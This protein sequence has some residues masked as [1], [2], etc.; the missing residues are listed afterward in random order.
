MLAKLDHF[1]QFSGW[2]KHIWNP[3]P[4][5]LDD[6]EN[7][8]LFQARILRFHVNLPRYD[9]FTSRPNRILFPH[10]V[11]SRQM[12]DHTSR[13]ARRTSPKV[14]LDL[15]GPAA[16]WGPKE[17]PWILWRFK[18]KVRCFNVPHKTWDMLDWKTNNW[19]KSSWTH[20][21]FFVNYLSLESF[22]CQTSWPNKTKLAINAPCP[23]Q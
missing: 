21:H 6:L 11:F 13:R 14:L 22:F 18:K 2:N 20:H 7:D 23:S 4:S 16:A 15:T 19:L 3:L 9:D 5:I 1:P 10:L 17:Q 12:N 8:F